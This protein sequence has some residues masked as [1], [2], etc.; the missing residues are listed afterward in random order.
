MK[1]RRFCDVF[2]SF[3]TKY[4]KNRSFRPF[5][6][7]IFFYLV[8]K[9][10]YHYH[11]ANQWTDYERN[12][13]LCWADWLNCKYKFSEN[14]YC[15]FSDNCGTVNWR[16]PLLS[17][18]HYWWAEE[19]RFSDLYKI[20]WRCNFGRLDCTH[21]QVCATSRVLLRILEMLFQRDGVVFVRIE[22][23]K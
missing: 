15:C 10:L 4:H 22:A 11:Y 14:C 19:L 1:K 3:W 12:C 17:Y 5:Q 2:W 16:L 7:T 13:C 6:T 18:R 21:C 9:A 20:F 23:K 8:L